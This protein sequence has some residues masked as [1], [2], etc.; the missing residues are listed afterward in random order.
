MSLIFTE[1]SSPS[2]LAC[3][4]SLGSYL[5]PEALL[6]LH[7]LSP[8]TRKNRSRLLTHGATLRAAVIRYTNRVLRM[9]PL[10][11]HESKSE[12]IWDSMVLLVS[13]EVQKSHTVLGSA[14]WHESFFI[15]DINKRQQQGH[16]QY[17]ALHSYVNCPDQHPTDIRQPRLT[18]NQQHRHPK[19]QDYPGQEAPYH[20][21]GTS[22][23]QRE[24]GSWTSSSERRDTAGEAQ[25]SSL[26]TFHVTANSSY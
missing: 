8:W 9:V 19:T 21:K 11:L 1:V 2:R 4:Y 7:C 6:Y 22:I 16:T 10:R 17:T 12:K 24:P 20:N 15:L 14:P 25:T 3:G 18:W 13:H 23:R 5:K 26:S